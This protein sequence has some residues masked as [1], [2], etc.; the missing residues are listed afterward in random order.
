MKSY[1][2]KNGEVASL[3][4][5]PCEN[6]GIFGAWL[7]D[8]LRAPERHC[9]TYHAFEWDGK[10]FLLAAVADDSD[11]TIA[12]AMTPAPSAAV[13]TLTHDAPALSM[14]E[15]ELAEN[16]GIDFVGHAW[17]KPVRYAFNRARRDLTMD[18]YP[19]FHIESDDTHEVGVGPIHAGVIEP[20]HFR[21]SCTGETVAHLEIQLGYQHRGVEALMLKKKSWLTKTVLIESVCGDAVCGHTIAY[22]AAVEGL[23]GL[24]LPPDVAWA[25]T[26]ALEMERIAV[27]IGDLSALN[28]DIAYQLGAATLGA[29]RTPMINY[30][31]F[32]CGNRFG[33]RLI[34]PGGTAYPFTT[35]L[36]D[37]L[38]TSLD[39]F[40]RVYK[41]ASDLMFELSSVLSR[42]EKTGEITN[43]QMR[44]IGA[45]GLVARIVGIERDVRKSHPTFWYPKLTHLPQVLTSGDVFAHAYLRMQEIYQSMGY[46]R[47]LLAEGADYFDKPA[48]EP[49]VP[50]LPPDSV[51]IS[52]VEG[53]RGEI[54]HCAISDA[55]GGLAHYKIKDPS[56]HNWF[57][58][59]LAVRNNE[60]S[61][62]PICNKSFDQSYCGHDL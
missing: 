62:F 57:A 5:V 7:A 32:W 23:S 61:D 39:S 12:L 3:N 26:V 42:L 48:H 34:C 1:I 10:R 11:A 14:F 59:A 22:A 18:N 15:R 16:F 40:E 45:V 52:L 49:P 19:F 24:P 9:V 53:W 6:Y 8:S 31:Q 2:V 25:R 27:H 51:C 13:P 20:G 41:E 17:L 43:G 4:D 60:I 21:F 38:S 33:R 30:F 28:T 46:V 35:A 54:C 36:A 29:L 56:F 37:R 58:L 55:N 44:Q 50:T 47:R